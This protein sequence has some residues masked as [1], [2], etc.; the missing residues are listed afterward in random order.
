MKKNSI[1]KNVV[2]LLTISFALS[3]LTNFKSYWIWE[4]T[5]TVDFGDNNLSSVVV[6][7]TNGGEVSFPLPLEKMVADFKNDSIPRYQSYNTQEQFL[8]TWVKGP[9]IFVQKFD[10]DSVVL[11]P[12]LQVNDSS[13][14][15]IDNTRIRSA[16]MDDSSFCVVWWTPT[17]Y[18]NK[19]DNIYGQTFSS[20]NKKMCLNFIIKYNSRYPSVWANDSSKVF[21]ILYSAHEGTE[22][23]ANK[24]FVQ[25]RDLYGVKPEDDFILNKELLIIS[26]MHSSAVSDKDGNLIVVW[27]GANG[28]SSNHMDIY[29]RKFSPNATPL[30]NTFK[31]NDDNLWAYQGTPDLSIDN[32]G[33]LLLAWTDFRDNTSEYYPYTYAIYGQFYDADINKLFD[34]F[35]INEPKYK[36][37]GS[38]DVEFIDG[39]FQV[40][41]SAHDELW[42]NRWKF[43]PVTYG[44]MI[45]SVF[46][47]GQDGANY[48]EIFWNCDLP[49][50]TSIN[51]KLRSAHNIEQIDNME[52]YGPLDINGFYNNKAGQMINP[53]HNLDRY[54]QYKVIFETE[55]PGIS[56]ILKS[57][58]ISYTPLDSI[59][60]SPPNNLVASVGHSQIRLS[61]QA[62]PDNDVMQYNLYR[63]QSSGN[64]QIDWTKQI[65]TH[66]TSYTDTSA[67]NGANYYYAI[68]AV[69]TSHNESTLSNEIFATPRI[70]NLFVS[71]SG[72]PTGD[73]TLENPYSSIMDAINAAE[74]GDSIVVLPGS[75]SESVTMKTGV[76]LIGSGARFTEL[77]GTNNEYIIKAANDAVIK[78]FSLIKAGSE[79]RHAIACQS[80]SPTISNNII[81]SYI[82]VM[83]PAI[84]CNNRVSPNIIK[85]YIS[86]F[87]VGINV[88]AYSTPLIRNNIIEVSDMG[89]TEGWF[90]KC[91]IFNNTIIIRNAVGISLRDNG[92]STVLNNIV[93]GTDYSYGITGEVYPERVRYNNAWNNYINFDVGSGVGNISENPLFINTAKQD[94]RLQDGSPCIDSGSPDSKYYDTDGSRNDMGAFGG[95]DP[96]RR[97]LMI[98]LVKSLSLS[99]TSGFPGDTV[100]FDVSLDEPAGLKSAV[101]VISYDSKLL[102]FKTAQTGTIANEFSFNV[103]ETSKG[104]VLLSLFNNKPIENGSGPIAQI[105]FMVSETAKSG[106]VS[107]LTVEECEFLDSES[108]EIVIKSISDGFFSVNLG[109]DEGQ[110]LYVDYKY[111]SSG[112]GSRYQP[113]TTIQAAIDQ[114]VAGD[115]IVVAAGDYSEQLILKEGV[116]LRG[117]GAIVTR[118]HPQF[119]ERCVSISDIQECE[120]SGFAFIGPDN[121]P[122]IM[123]FIRISN[124]SPIIKANL[125]QAQ[126]LS[127]TG[128]ECNDNSS[129]VI[130]RNAFINCGIYVSNSNPVIHHNDIIGGDNVIQCNGSSPIITW[131]RID[132]HEG[133]MEAIRLLECKNATIEKNII[134]VHAGAAFGLIIE[135]SD[136]IFIFNNII[137]GLN[138][139]NGVWNRYSTNI[140]F[141]N[142]TIHSKMIGYNEDESNSLIMNNIIIGNNDCGIQ[143]CNDTEMDYNNIWNPGNNYCDCSAGINSIS[144]DPLFIN[145]EN[146]NYHLCL[147]SPC[148]NL[149]NPDEQ[150][151][152]WDGSR[153]DMGAF[154]GPNADPIWTEIFGCTIKADSLVAT[155][156]DTIEVSVYGS[157]IENIAQIYFDISYDPKKIQFINAYATEVS[158]CLA[159]SKTQSASN[160]LSITMDGISGIQSKQ[161]KLLKLYFCVCTSEQAVTYIRFDSVTLI[162][163]V[164]SNITFSEITDG[165]ITIVKANEIDN[166]NHIP[167]TYSL[168]QCYPNPFNAF[169]TIKY[170]I[171][172]AGKVNLNI[173]DIRGRKVRT[174]V[175]TI[176]NTGNYSLIWDGSN[177]SGQN[178]ASGIYFY[179]IHTEKY[180]KTKKMILL[181]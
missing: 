18:Y 50:K 162:S 121:M 140:N 84:Y 6:V 115:T 83:V 74:Y 166:Q 109:S 16:L 97:E 32:N 54:I 133:G 21:W 134:S 13:I 1:M 53:I 81:Q 129:A 153:N 80:T 98:R 161:G 181:K 76:S 152:D 155:L 24:I 62:P 159:L 167:L 130:D 172:V 132:A 102:D 165:V 12:A 137:K 120:I 141:V 26:E 68:S 111:D 64:Y 135:N 158:N 3:A 171:A 107:Q 41:W 65:P 91:S 116:Y 178:L 106:D 56:P 168:D 151:N 44:E 25:Q 52:W 39:E 175:N 143:A 164:M 89:I 90:A 138:D 78:G 40:S 125:F 131:N 160:T 88:G 136:S 177:D 118:I 61:W 95:P 108:G 145:P 124:S 148:I 101:M 103:K 79:S 19:D 33:N 27:E 119:D 163:D 105:D 86:G 43:I 126:I 31:V 71:E 87:A 14:I 36:S 144:D 169:T 57:I 147:N 93:V 142:N 139:G 174:L 176:K 149:G 46:D 11:S 157:Q 47:A 67:V 92:S 15:D 113:F 180:I 96:I 60:P 59:A 4:E 173:Y 114:S 34:N 7:N 150:F 28:E 73:G 85:N 122:C 94:Y 110:Y 156:N 45:S 154:G 37:N 72:S 104:R 29:I 123:P 112:D 146:G 70:V 99:R 17:S 22:W 117:A 38:P 10:A 23:Y 51:I 179:Q 58:S 5:S 35:R 75:Y 2:M 8:N 66:L 30:S 48:H 82:T 100:R 127:F 128:I 170:Q 49:D 77:M 63:G 20:S 55:S 69:D 9:N 42:I